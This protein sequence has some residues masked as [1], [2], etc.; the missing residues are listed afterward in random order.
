MVVVASPEFFQIQ[1]NR[2]YTHILTGWRE[3]LV[4]TPKVSLITLCSLP[5]GETPL[6]VNVPT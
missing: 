6:T 1:G 3:F 4:A 5:R 2:T